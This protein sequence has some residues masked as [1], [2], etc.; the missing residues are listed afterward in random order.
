MTPDFPARLA[1][2]TAS[3]RGHTD[4]RPDLAIIAGTGLGPML[5]AI[6]DAW[7]IPYRQIA[8]FPHS[9]APSHKGELVLG[10]LG[11]RQVVAM[12][13]RFHAY[14][15]WTADDIVLPV[16]AMAA[17]GA[18]RLVVTN[19]AGGLNPDY[20]VPAV[21]LIEDHL[22]L[23]GLHPL[24][25]PNDDRLGLRFPDLSRAYD[26]DLRAAALAAA[27]RLGMD[28]QRGVYVGCH[29]PELETSAERRFMRAIGGDAVGMSTVLE[30]IAANHAGMRVLGLSA[31]A[32]AATGG[33]EQAADTVESIVAATRQVAGRLQ[34]LVISML[35]S[36]DL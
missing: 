21:M 33:P 13:G 27:A 25:G 10:R 35:D 34:A 19:C 1:R 36:G 9:T 7:R 6:T 17:L 30:V 16:Y 29:G 3:L 26:P 14:E 23:T 28:L 2:V 22:N 11:G 12:D 5:D 31:I 4:L 15:G 24:A 8:D 32:N 20:P 18:K